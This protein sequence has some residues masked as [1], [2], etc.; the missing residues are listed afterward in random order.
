[1]LGLPTNRWRGGSI[2]SVLA[3]VLGTVKY[4]G[5]RYFVRSGSPWW[6]ICAV[7]SGAT[8]TYCLALMTMTI[9][10]PVRV[11][12]MH[13]WLRGVALMPLPVLVWILPRAL[14]G[15]VR[16]RLIRRL[17]ATDRMLCTTC[18]Y[19]LRGLPAR[20]SCPECGEEFDIESVQRTWAQWLGSDGKRRA[21]AS[22]AP[23]SDGGPGPANEA[24]DK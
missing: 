15:F 1:M 7:L 6:R 17:V 16:R 8:V 23:R 4:D 11:G 20:H 21:L 10:Q 5:P 18:G 3:V 14:F 12:T 2:L 22:G 9:T 24:C 13:T 19:C